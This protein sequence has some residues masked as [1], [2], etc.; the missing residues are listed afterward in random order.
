M[1]EKKIQQRKR[2]ERLQKDLNIY[3]NLTKRG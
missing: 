2:G 1:K 3:D